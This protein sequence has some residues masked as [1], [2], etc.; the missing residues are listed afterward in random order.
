MKFHIE[1]FPIDGVY[2]HGV[3]LNLSTQLDSETIL[4]MRLNL[5]ALLALLALVAAWTKEGE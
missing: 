3:P 1:P 5:W 4:I 2:V